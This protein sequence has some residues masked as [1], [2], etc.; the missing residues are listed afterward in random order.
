MDSERL[1]R[2]ANRERMAFLE[3]L[4]I[5]L[6]HS[7]VVGAEPGPVRGD[8]RN[9]REM[10]QGRSDCHVAAW[11]TGTRRCVDLPAGAHLSASWNCGEAM[12]AEHTMCAEHWLLYG[13]MAICAEH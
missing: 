10:G 12:C 11:S 6:A 9:C 5:A 13:A 1:S 4:W 3:V 7:S 8:C 2:S